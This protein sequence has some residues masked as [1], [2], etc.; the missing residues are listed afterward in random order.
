MIRGD[1]VADKLSLTPERIENL[2]KTEVVGV[3]PSDDRVFLNNAR[4]IP[5]DSVAFKAFKLLGNNVLNHKNK[6]FDY[7]ADYV[8]FFGSIRRGLKRN[9]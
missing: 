4:D 7:T 8:G 1:L 9:L 6:I 2:L 5:S 3:I